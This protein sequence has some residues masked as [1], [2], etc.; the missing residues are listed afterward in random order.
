MGKIPIEEV[1]KDISG[2]KIHMRKSL[3]VEGAGVV[4]S[5]GRPRTH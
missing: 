1:G 3:E 2:G 5:D 4:E